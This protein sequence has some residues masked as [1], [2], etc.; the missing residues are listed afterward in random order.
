LQSIKNRLSIAK[1]ITV[2]SQKS[3]NTQISYKYEQ[4][5]LPKAV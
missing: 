3:G 1:G 4:Y 2:I 5:W